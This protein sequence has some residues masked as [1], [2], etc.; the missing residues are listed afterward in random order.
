MLRFRDLGMFHHRSVRG[1][2]NAHLM[3]AQ[4]Q[5]T[6]ERTRGIRESSG[7]DIGIQLAGCVN[8]FHVQGSKRVASSGQPKNN[9]L[10]NDCSTP[11]E[12]Q[13]L[14]S[15][16]KTFWSCLTLSIHDYSRTLV[17]VPASAEIHP[18]LLHRNCEAIEFQ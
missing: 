15:L 11:W 6:S 18:G 8:D 1:K 10:Q 7:L 3:P 4:W 5:L 12:L 2:K 13:L 9:A 17:G 16:G 14:Y